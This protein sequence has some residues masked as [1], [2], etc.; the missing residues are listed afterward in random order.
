MERWFRLLFL[1]PI[2]ND[3]DGIGGCATKLS[4]FMASTDIN[5]SDKKIQGRTQQDGRYLQAAEDRGLCGAANS[6]REPT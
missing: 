5:E 4:I 1:C 6:G 3:D 2:A